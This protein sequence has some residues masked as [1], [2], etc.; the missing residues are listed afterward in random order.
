LLDRRIAAYTSQSSGCAKKPF[1]DQVCAISISCSIELE[2]GV[3]ERVYF[4]QILA[5]PV[6]L[7]PHNTH[8]TAP[9]HS[10]VSTLNA[11]TSMNSFAF[12][13]LRPFRY[14]YSLGAPVRSIN[15]SVRLIHRPIQREHKCL[16]KNLPIIPMGAIVFHHLLKISCVCNWNMNMNM[17]LPCLG[18]AR[19]LWSTTRR[20]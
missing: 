11:P 1:E 9:S 4:S 20:L 5:H 10:N 18:R 3:N 8:T 14:K 2:L 17:I 12:S 19:Y 13:L 16:K 15:A 7:N 6:S